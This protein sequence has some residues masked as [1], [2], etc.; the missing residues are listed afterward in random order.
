MFSSPVLLSHSMCR[1]EY[2]CVMRSS[3]L[4]SNLGFMC[5]GGSGGATSKSGF[6]ECFGNKGGLARLR[7]RIESELCERATVESRSSS[8]P[9]SLVMSGKEFP[10]AKDWL[11]SLTAI[12]F[13]TTMTALLT[14]SITFSI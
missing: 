3:K 12:Q 10:L 5:F 7:S 2:E 4:L 8:W 14:G 9:M 11:P 13:T 1:N 6:K